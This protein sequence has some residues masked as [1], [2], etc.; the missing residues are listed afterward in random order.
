MVSICPSLLLVVRPLLQ[1]MP[2]I[3][4]QL[5]LLRTIKNDYK[6][7]IIC[8]CVHFYKVKKVFPKCRTW[9]RLD[10]HIMTETKPMFEMKSETRCFCAIF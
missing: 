8:S 9:M 2:T 1:L 5:P 10:R 6:S 4:I 7:T 3:T